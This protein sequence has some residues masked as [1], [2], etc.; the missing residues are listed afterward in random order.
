MAGSLFKKGYTALTSRDIRTVITGIGIVSPIGIGNEK[1]WQNLLEGKP[2]FKPITLF[3]TGDLKVKI[4]GEITEFDPE[5]IPGSKNMRDTDRATLLLLGAADIAFND[6]GL[7][8]DNDNT[9]SMGVVAGTTF[10]SL[11]SISDFDQESLREGPQY[12]NPSIFPS[13]VANSP[14]SRLNIRYGIKGLS[15]TVSTGM[16]ASLDALDYGRDLIRLGRVNTIVVGAVGD[17]SIQTFLGCYKLHYLSGITDGDPISCPFDK[18]RNGI[19]LAEGS[20]VMILEEL[21]VA[22]SRH[23]KIYAE[24]L[25]LGSCFDTNGLYNYNPAGDGMVKAMRLALDEAEL[26]PGDISCIFASANSTQN[27][28]SIEA[29]AIRKVFADIADSI[30]VTAIKSSI[31]EG[32]S[33]SGGF[34]TAAACFSIR[35]GLIPPI[36]GYSER[37]PSCD[38]RYVTG[39]AEKNEV[40]NVMINTFDPSGA[41][42]VLIAS[43][44]N[45]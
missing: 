15:S 38:L 37:D 1:Y 31:G 35:D 19:I 22:L 6:A 16:C 36:A 42:T 29:K 13:T 44:F 5:N 21:T 23:A 45:G 2:G 3:D 40:N 14:A 34:A 10:G 7:K 11:S 32:Y 41:N 20:V 17:L 25:G 30:P 4:A 9:H 43:K 28:D 12:V 8:I 33:V 18:R 27:G 39:H 26:D 24:V